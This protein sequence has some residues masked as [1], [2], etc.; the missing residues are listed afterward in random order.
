MKCV[1]LPV[2]DSH[3]PTRQIGSITDEWQSS[4]GSKHV[5]FA[6]DNTPENFPQ[7]EG[8]SNGFFS[9]LSL[10]HK[11]GSP[12]PIP[13]EVSICIE[14][15]TRSNKLETVS[16]YKKRTLASSNSE[17]A[18]APSCQTIHQ[19][20]NPWT[21]MPQTTFSQQRSPRKCPGCLNETPNKPSDQVGVQS[22]N[23]VMS[24]MSQPLHLWR[25]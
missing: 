24:M 1:G 18:K 14:V 9:E 4:N 15:S 25:K 23:D 8:L 13:L 16:E 5:A 22:G 3:D 17:S 21:R 7:I 19:P 10:S 20:P 12:H 2:Y 6:I 11:L